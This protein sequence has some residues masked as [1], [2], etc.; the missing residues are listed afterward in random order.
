MIIFCV[1]DEPQSLCLPTYGVFYDICLLMVS[2]DYFQLQSVA[3][4]GHQNCLAT[5]SRVRF[6]PR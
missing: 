6:L 1:T 2:I 4:F 3:S 5:V